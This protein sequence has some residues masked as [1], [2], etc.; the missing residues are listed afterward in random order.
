MTIPFP[1]RSDPPTRTLRARPGVRDGDRVRDRTGNA[2]V[3]LA[4][5]G[6]ARPDS[7]AADSLGPPKR[8]ELW[9]MAIVSLAI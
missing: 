4:A 2:A 6:D 3:N 1:I 7:S 5:G 9:A 8:H